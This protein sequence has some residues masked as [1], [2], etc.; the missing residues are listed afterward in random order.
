MTCLGDT[1][2]FVLLRQQIEVKLKM[3]AGPDLFILIAK[4]K[5]DPETF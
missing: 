3:V 4:A 2:P 1:L 5:S